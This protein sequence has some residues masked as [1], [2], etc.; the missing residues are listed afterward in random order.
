MLRKP[1]VIA[2]NGMKVFVILT[3]FDSRAVSCFTVLQ[4]KIMVTETILCK[5]LFGDPCSRDEAIT[6]KI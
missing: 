4:L 3:W 2:D 6:M 5:W 1:V